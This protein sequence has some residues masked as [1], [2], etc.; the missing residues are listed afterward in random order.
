MH[1]LIDVL[2]YGASKPCTNC[3]NGRY[4][5]KSSAYLC[6]G[7]SSEWSPCNNHVKEPERQPTMIPQDIQ[8]MYPSL[9][10]QFLVRTRLLRVGSEHATAVRDLSGLFDEVSDTQPNLQKVEVKSKRLIHYK[11]LV[12]T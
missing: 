10:R 7:Q 4:V 3:P 5:F 8:D 6:N 1:H 2:Y 12:L 11:L 9:A